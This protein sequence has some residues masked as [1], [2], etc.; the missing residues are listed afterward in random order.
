MLQLADMRSWGAIWLVS[1]GVQLVSLFLFTVMLLCYC[2]LALY[3]GRT[4]RLLWEM[5]QHTTA[6]TI[7]TPI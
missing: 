4:W 6:I 1:D 7:N 2:S 3:S 5:R